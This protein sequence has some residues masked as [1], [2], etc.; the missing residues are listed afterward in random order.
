[1]CRCSTYLDVNKEVVEKA[2]LERHEAPVL[3]VVHFKDD[4]TGENKVQLK[5]Q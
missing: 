3:E 5:R 2:R 1:M 4:A